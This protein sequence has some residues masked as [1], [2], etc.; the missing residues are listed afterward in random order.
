MNSA[1]LSAARWRA[2][3]LATALAVATW[4]A[5]SAAAKADGPGIGTASVASLGDSYISGEAGRWAGNTN[6]ELVVD[7]RARLDRVLRQRAG[8]RPRRSAAATARKS[9]EVYIGGGVS[10]VNLACSGAKTSTF[11]RRR[12]LQARPRLLQLGRQT[13]PGADAPELRGERTT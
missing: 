13:G 12:Q 6:E 4:A 10:G 1:G 7:R 5:W 2:A 8:T 9:A 11:T 3:I